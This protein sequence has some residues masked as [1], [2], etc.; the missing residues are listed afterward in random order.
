MMS[1]NNLKIITWKVLFCPGYKGVT[2]KSLQHMYKAR[3]H[4]KVGRKISVPVK[5]PFKGVE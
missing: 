2:L 3:D 1:I 5:R 4:H